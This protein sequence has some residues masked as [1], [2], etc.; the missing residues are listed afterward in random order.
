[1]LLQVPEI[2]DILWG[3]KNSRLSTEI[4]NVLKNNSFFVIQLG[5]ILDFNMRFDAMKMNA[6]SIPNDI[7][8]VKRQF[9][10]RSKNNI[11]TI[12]QNYED[13]F[14]PSALADMS[15]YYIEPNPALKSMI[16]II[17][18]Y[19]SDG[20]SEDNHHLDLLVS[21]SKICTKIL[22][23]D[24]KAKYERFGTVGMLCRIMV[25]TALLYDHLHDEGVFV[26]ESP[27]SIKLILDILEE[28]AGLKRKRTRSRIDTPPSFKSRKEGGSRASQD[29]YQDLQEECRNLLNV[30]KYSNK[31]LKSST[32]PR[33][34]EQR[35]NQI[36]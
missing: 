21:F 16:K 1:M 26:K 17:N 20:K 7:S 30:L 12:E 8:Y 19:F 29:S 28:E 35:F 22:D 18:D 27:I 31:H 4:V 13:V 10:I 33:S 14:R 5:K 15:K 34:V 9:T 2:L 24:F 11:S 23:S 32:T 25:A 6:P 36:F 3:R